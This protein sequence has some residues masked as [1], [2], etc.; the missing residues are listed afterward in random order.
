MHSPG[1]MMTHR[2]V[3]KIS[4]N[5]LDFYP[6]KNDGNVDDD[7]AHALYLASKQR[8]KGGSQDLSNSR[9]TTKMKRINK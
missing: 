5:N 7:Q 2:F 3:P 9:P 4:E 6:C 1:K 8:G